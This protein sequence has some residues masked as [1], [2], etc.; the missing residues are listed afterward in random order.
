MSWMFA[1]LSQQFLDRVI[2]SISCPLF[3][4]WVANFFIDGPNAAAAAQQTSFASDLYSPKYSR[5]PNG[6]FLGAILLKIESLLL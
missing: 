6:L 4:M 3:Q 5:W 2:V 1:L